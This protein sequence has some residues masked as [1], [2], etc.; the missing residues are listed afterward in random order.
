MWTES[1]DVGSEQ[2]MEWTE[3]VPGRNAK[4]R[5]RNLVNKEEIFQLREHAVPNMANLGIKNDDIGGQNRSF[6]NDSSYISN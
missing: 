3:E 6:W 2:F 1:I 5:G 4:G